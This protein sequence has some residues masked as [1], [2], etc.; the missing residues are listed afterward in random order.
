VRTVLEKA[1]GETLGDTLGTTECCMIGTS[2]GADIRSPLER[3]VGNSLG[4]DEGS[5][6]GPS[7]GCGEWRTLGI[8]EVKTDGTSDGKPLSRAD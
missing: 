1:E 2:D 5:R 4:R 6:L 8:P 7:L 3:H